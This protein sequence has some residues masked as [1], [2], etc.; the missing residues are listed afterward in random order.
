[1]RYAALAEAPPGQATEV[2][3]YA[4]LAGAQGPGLCFRLGRAAW[5][6]GLGLCFRLGRVV[7][8]RF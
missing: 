3:R 7:W 8:V 4:A 1:M 6:Q 5:D 2:T